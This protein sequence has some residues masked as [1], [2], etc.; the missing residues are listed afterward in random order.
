M[1][2]ARRARLFDDQVVRTV[3]AIREVNSRAIDTY[4]LATALGSALF[5][6]LIALILGWAALR[7]VEPVVLS[8]FV[9]VLLFVKGPIDQ[10][11]GALPGVGRARVAFQ[12][13]ADL[14]T[15][16]ASPEPHLDLDQPLSELALDDAIELRCRQ[17]M[18]TTGS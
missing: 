17:G 2:R 3:D 15:F 14:S 10:I 7:T 6:L 1:H 11:A 12:R 9:L 16:F 13:I 18:A 8:G 5:F 4:V